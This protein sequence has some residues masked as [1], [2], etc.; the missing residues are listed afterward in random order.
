MKLD[1][2]FPQLTVAITRSLGHVRYNHSFV[3]V[4]PV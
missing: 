2:L 4:V 3:E 1:L